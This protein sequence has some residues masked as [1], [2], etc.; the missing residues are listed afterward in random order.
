MIQNRGSGSGG[1]SAGSTDIFY[2]SRKKPQLLFQT[3]TIS[4]EWERAAAISLTTAPR[5]EGELPQE[6]RKNVRRSQKRGVV[7]KVKGLDD[8]LVQAMVGVNKDSPVR[9]QRSFDHYGKTF[10]QVRKDQSSFLD[11]SDFICAYLGEELIGFLK[12]VYIGRVA[13]ILQLLPKASPRTKAW[14][15]R[16]QRR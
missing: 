2:F 10:D 1:G 8:D 13:S 6:T 9:Q 15:C 11:R 5:F 3:L 14:Q 4:Q 12:L 7:V 16:D